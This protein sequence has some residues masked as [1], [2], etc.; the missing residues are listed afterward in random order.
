MIYNTLK[1]FSSKLLKDLG[2]TVSRWLIMDDMEVCY[3][4]Q[5]V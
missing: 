5:I 3:G 2:K 4:K 1:Q